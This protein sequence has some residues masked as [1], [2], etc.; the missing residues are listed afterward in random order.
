MAVKRHL[1]QL[2]AARVRSR[3]RYYRDTPV[4]IPI[5]QSKRISKWKVESLQRDGELRLQGGVIDANRGRAA[6]FPISRDQRIDVCCGQL[7]SGSLV[8]PPRLLH[9]IQAFTNL[10]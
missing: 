4:Q 7:H 5:A 6:R 10:A 8:S 1:A 9:R 3:R 2:D